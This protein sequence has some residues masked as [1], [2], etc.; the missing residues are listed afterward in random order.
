MKPYKSQIIRRKCGNN[1]KKLKPAGHGTASIRTNIPVPQ[2]I[3][4][5]IY[6]N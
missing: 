5:L 4:N 6:S 3:F 1:F 2:M